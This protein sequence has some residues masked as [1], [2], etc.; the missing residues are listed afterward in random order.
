MGFYFLYLIS[1][2]IFAVIGTEMARARNRDV[3]VWGLICFVTGLLGIIVLAVVGDE[4]SED[5]DSRAPRSGNQLGYVPRETVKKSY[6]EKKWSALKEFDPDIAQAA[7]QVAKFGSVAE[8]RLATA[9]LAIGDKSLLSAMVGKLVTEE[10]TALAEQ[11]QK[12]AERVRKAAELKQTMSG[13]QLQLLVDREKRARATLEQ[14]QNDGMMLDGKKVVSAEMYVSD[15]AHKQG[16][17]KV[18]YENGREE[19][20]A[21]ASMELLKQAAT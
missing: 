4:S 11:E 5:T 17:L 6:D 10:S 3:A 12:N 2:A 8:D 16:W 7:A 1:G 20:R 19:L 15:L 13:Q 18:V 21:G 14:I 9:Y